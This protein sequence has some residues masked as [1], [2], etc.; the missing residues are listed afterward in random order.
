MEPPSCTSVR[1]CTRVFQNYFNIS[2]SNVVTIET[3][4]KPINA[5]PWVG[6]NGAVMQCCTRW[7]KLNAAAMVW[8]HPFTGKANAVCYGVASLACFSRVLLNCGER[9]HV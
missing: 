7:L 3:I 1:A 2:C 4:D 6:D 9:A 8:G 5:T